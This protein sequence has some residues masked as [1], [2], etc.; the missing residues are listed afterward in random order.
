MHTF[1]SSSCFFW[2]KT[3]AKCNISYL[4]VLWRW[5][6]WCDLYWAWKQGTYW[7]AN[8]NIR[9]FVVVYCYATINYCLFVCFFVCFFLIYLIVKNSPK[10]II[11]NHFLFPDKTN[12]YLEIPRK[13][14]SFFNTLY[15]K[16][17]YGKYPHYRWVFNINRVYICNHFL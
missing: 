6:S 13:G 5:G 4:I 11:Y 7:T 16:G 12:Y 14:F 3:A 1:T 8:K 9:I 10:W 2:P 17:W 15:K